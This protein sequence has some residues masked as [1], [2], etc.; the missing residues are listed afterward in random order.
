MDLATYRSEFAWHRFRT[1][2]I[3]IGI[4]F[5][6]RVA[7]EES[8]LKWLADI[9]D[10]DA[11]I[12]LNSLQLAMESI[13][14]NEHCDKMHDL[15]WMKLASIQDGI[16]V[17]VNR[18]HYPNCDSFR[19]FDFS[20]RS[21]MLYDRQGDQHYDM[22]SALHKSIRASDEN[23]TL[24]WCAR[25]MAGGEDPRYICRRLVRAASEDIGLADPHAVGIA[26][27][28]LDAVQLVG[29]PESDC[30]IAQAAVY[31]AR[32]PKSREV[33]DALGLC[34]RDIQ[35]CKGPQPAVPLHLRN[36]PT[37]L[38]RELGKTAEAFAPQKIDEIC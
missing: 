18:A 11:R 23:A 4:R 22:I 28:T 2:W 10:G 36:A 27:T 29:M 12:A 30:I 8:S 9:C 33:H 19:I 7:V 14:E 15:K 35:E 24:Y 13:L 16:K 17:S 37:K 32:A 20:Q 5:V 1:I 3:F 31:L 38:M 34:K 6:H 25:M 21:H 26:L